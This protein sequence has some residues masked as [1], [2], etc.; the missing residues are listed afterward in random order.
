MLP[1]DLHKLRSIAQGYNIPDIFAKTENQLRQEIE[2]KQI[3]HLPKQ[4]EVIPHNPYDAR[5]MTRPPAKKSNRDS[6][7]ELLQEHIRR[8]LHVDFPDEETWEMR[9]AKKIDTGNIRIPLR[10]ILQCANKVMA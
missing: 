3:E 6:I 5:L 7:L 10:T 2:L 4:K 8:G 9:Y 1:K